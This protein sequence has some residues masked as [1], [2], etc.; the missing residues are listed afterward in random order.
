MADNV[1]VTAGTGTSVAADEV[2]DA[3][4]GTVKVQ[5]VK[6]M[7]GTLD[8]ATK[9]VVGATGLKVDAS[10]AT[11]PV[12]GTFWQATQPVSAASL[13][14]PTG[15][16]AEATVTSGAQVT[17]IR[18]AIL[19]VTAVGAAAAAVTNTLPAAGVGLFHYITRINIVK[20]NTVAV[21]GGVTP[22]TATSTNLPGSPAWTFASAAAVG[23]VAATDLEP[24]SPIR[25]AVANTATTIV[26]PATASVLWRITVYY[27]TAA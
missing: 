13:P 18:A 6:I 14:L 20:Y 15:A 3:T 12:T 19:A 25:S 24:S 17:Q 22:V 27:F 4:L 1:A 23:T 8:G 7:D 5:F 10:S 11:V 2:V 26:G 21:V 9:A 16:V